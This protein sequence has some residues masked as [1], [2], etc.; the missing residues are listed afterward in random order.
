MLKNILCILLNILE[1]FEIY[2]MPD[3][4]KVGK[5][6]LFSLKITDKHINELWELFCCEKIE[7]SVKE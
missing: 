3:K 4:K 5:V 2:C 7:T 6:M 1:N